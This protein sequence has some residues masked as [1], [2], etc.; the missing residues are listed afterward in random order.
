MSINGANPRVLQVSY[1]ASSVIADILKESDPVTETD[2]S[3]LGHHVFCKKFRF[4]ACFI[5]G[6]PGEPNG[7]NVG[8]GLGG[9]G[10]GGGGEHA[11]LFS[12]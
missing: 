7:K 9:G 11:I 5:T 3:G 4:V 12:I 1:S 10:T 8:G 2:V 6:L